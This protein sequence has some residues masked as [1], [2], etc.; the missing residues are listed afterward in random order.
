MTRYHPA[1]K[2][3]VSTLHFVAMNAKADIRQFLA[4]AKWFE[5][6]PEPLLDRLVN[7]ASIKHFEAGSH[8]W[9]V[10][11][12]TNTLYGLIHGR[13]RLYQAS[14]SG[15][16][17]A[18][19]DWEDGAWFG[20]QTLAVDEPNMLGVKV[21]EPSDILLL[22]SKSVQQVAGEWPVFYEKLFKYSW[23]NTRGL[24][25]I[26][27]SIVF[28]PLKARIAGRVLQL[29]QEHGSRTDEGFLLN[30]RLSQND[31]ASLSMGSRQRVNAIF[32]EWTRQG[33]I[34]YR[35]DYLLIKK[36]QALAKEMTP[37]E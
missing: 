27:S 19:A 8:I 32:R 16:E 23:Y 30:V 20:E 10:G 12:K 24:Y 17:Y 28:Y 35:D 11:D 9:R 14:E 2:R 34:D 25:E 13:I 1:V 29:I 37:F 21:L 26:I 5:D 7:A 33:L 15:Q 22:P 4:S 6:I 31:F 3:S 36:P 18:L